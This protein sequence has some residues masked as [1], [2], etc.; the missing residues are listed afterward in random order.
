[1]ASNKLA[2]MRYKIID[3]CLRRR[4]RKWTLD[5]LVN[6]V[7]EE[8]YER[9]GITS[10]S[11]RTIQY[12][13]QFMRDANLGYGAPI[14]IKDKKYY[15]YSD[16]A[17][18]ITQ[19]PLSLNDVEKM[20]DAIGIL[21]YFNGFSYFEEMN[22]LIA[23]LEANVTHYQDES[24]ISI[25]IEEN[26][27]VHGLKCI[28]VLHKAIREEI[29]VLIKYKSFKSQSPTQD[30]YHP[31]LL[32]EYRNRWFLI[33]RNN[34]N[35]TLLTLALDRIQEVHEMSKKDFKPYKGVSF[36][37]YYSDLIGVTKSEKDRPQKVIL[38]VD[39][40]NAPYVETKPLHH[41]QQIIKAEQDG[42]VWF[43]IDVIPN[44]ELERE[45]LGFG[46]SMKVMA[47][48]LLRDRIIRR[49]QKMVMNYTR[50][51]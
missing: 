38:V 28:P 18:S 37:R 2:L 6:K 12:D 15:E 44:F 32:K 16:P 35:Q 13:I 51:E 34:R 21:K 11:K 36:D 39:A 8:L 19:S 43:R 10:I 33:C 50:K 9:E 23:R 41:S 25:Q 49:M 20:K 5:N 1:M 30:I 48:R 22:D 14:V 4:N 26:P 31:Y 27:L 29:P 47:P 40:K 7:A 46:E 24:K 17:Y 42:S 3:N 45:I